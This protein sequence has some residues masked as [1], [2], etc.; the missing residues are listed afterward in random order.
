MPSIDTQKVT[1]PVG[2]LR[3]TQV[4]TSGER[5]EVWVNPAL[6][7]TMRWDDF[8]KVTKLSIVDLE[9]QL[10]VAESAA[11]IAWRIREGRF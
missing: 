1:A 10:R 2:F 5:G 8:E 6:I 7:Q 3:L 9:M 4:Y 11:D